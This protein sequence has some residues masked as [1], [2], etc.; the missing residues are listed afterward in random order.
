MPDR[1]TYQDL[2]SHLLRLRSFRGIK[3]LPEREPSVPEP[4]TP[5][6]RLEAEAAELG[7]EV[8]DLRD[9]EKWPRDAEYDWREFGWPPDKSRGL[10]KGT[11]P[12]SQIT[13]ACLHTYAA[14]GMS[15]KRFLGVPCHIGLASN[16]DI[17]LCHHFTQYMWCSDAANSFS[18]GVE[19]SGP[20]RFDN[21]E[22]QTGSG[23]AILRY[24]RDE[25]LRNRPDDSPYG[26][27]MAVM[28]H[29][30]AT[31][32]KPDCCGKQIWQA[33]GEWAIAEAGYKLGPVVGDGRSVD[34]WR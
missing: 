22:I 27:S 28:A 6:E 16:G 12:W 15:W 20:G 5:L 21:P 4:V 32:K 10:P 17:V 33:L 34:I 24:I 13:A 29:R 26:D 1:Y 31:R 7:V 25:T 11:R 2:L 19:I 14:A 30:M 9:L 23:R 8:V 18:V 3:T